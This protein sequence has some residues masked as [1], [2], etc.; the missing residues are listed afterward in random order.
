MTTCKCQNCDWEG[1]DLD[2]RPVK[3]FHERVTPGETQPMGECPLCGSLAHLSPV[4]EDPR[5]TRA[6]GGI[7]SSTGGNAR[8]V[9]GERRDLNRSE[10]QYRAE[11]GL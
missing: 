9:D 2:L 8:L 1:D 3:R 4:P 6:M 10:A 7:G 11:R 5:V